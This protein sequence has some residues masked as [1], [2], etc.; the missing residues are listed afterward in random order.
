VALAATICSIGSI[1]SA[2]AGATPASGCA[3]SFSQ[4]GS[5]SPGVYNN[6]LSAVAPG[7][8]GEAWAVGLQRPKTGGPYTA[9][10]ER[11]SGKRFRIQDAPTPKYGELMGVDAI[12][13]DL[14]IAVGDAAGALLIERWDGG[15]WTIDP[16]APTIAATLRAID[17]RSPTDAWTVG[18][19]PAH[20]Q[21]LPYASR[22][23]GQTWTKVAMQDTGSG[24]DQPAS[25][26][27][28]TAGD[29]WAVG[30]SFDAN[31][32]ASTLVEH[33]D[34]ARW[35]IVPSPDPGSSSNYLAAV[36][37][38]RADDAWAV[39]DQ[40]SDGT[41][42]PLVLHWDGHSWTQAADAMTGSGSLAG[43]AGTGHGDVW[44]AGATYAG[45]GQAP[46]AEHWDGVAWTAVPAE[47][48][49]T[50]TSPYA[51]AEASPKKLW[52]VGQTFDDPDQG[53]FTLA[54]RFHCAT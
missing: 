44:E 49:L 14:A 8:P 16:A 47:Q 50:S 39:G 26:S 9:L 41:L 35:S 3:G 27:A 37:A 29:A 25:V 54:E 46:F 51:I 6:A 2:T 22:W 43:L 7:A 13:S 5:D 42:D 40:E 33:W 10:I 31:G 21:V 32:D 12:G 11:Y 53:D 17:L 23:N 48:A 34:G 24:N 15:A 36:Y 30:T 19:R 4:V 28:R 38:A 52:I 20:G 18:Y 45:G 1:P